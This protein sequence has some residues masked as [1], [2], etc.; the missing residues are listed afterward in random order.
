LF[1]KGLKLFVL[2]FALRQHF[3]IILS[4]QHYYLNK[5]VSVLR[6]A[7]SKL[8]AWAHIRSQFGLQ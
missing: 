7:W 5:Y 2:Q 1:T 8:W 3:K 6:W 4:V